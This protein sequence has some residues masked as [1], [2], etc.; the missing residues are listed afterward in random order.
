MNKSTKLWAMTALLNIYVTATLSLVACSKDDPVIPDVDESIVTI[1]ISEEA[2][3]MRADIKASGG[4]K[5]I[6]TEETW[7]V[8]MEY[9]QSQSEQE[10]PDVETMHRQGHMVIA[11]NDVYTLENDNADCLIIYLHGGAYCFG[12]LDSHIVFCDKLAQRMNAKVYM[13]LYPILLKSTCLD[14]FRFLQEVYADVLREGNPVILMGDSS[15]GG[16]ALAFAER[17][18][19][20]GDPM[21]ERLVLLSPWIDVTMINPAIP[22]LEGGD[23]ILSAYGLAG[24]GKLWAGEMEIKDSRV[25]PLYD[26][27]TGLPPT[28]IF[29]GTDEILRP[30]ITLLHEKMKAAGTKCRLVIGEGLWHVFPSYDIPERDISIDMI[31]TG[32]YHWRCSLLGRQLC[33]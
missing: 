24:L 31:A 30:D 12:I 33:H 28:L 19:D 29:C 9:L 17:L 26:S 1:P 22:S 10:Y 13:P 18:R 21:P 5:Y 11:D 32:F 27:M 4:Q 20:N 23:F 16:L 2:A 6:F 3:K 14:A 25:S 8:L 15:G 7:P